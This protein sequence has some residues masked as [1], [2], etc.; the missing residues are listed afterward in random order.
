MA[1][2]PERAAEFY[3]QVFGW[4]ISKWDGPEEYWLLTTGSGEEQ[5]ID[6]GIAR[7]KGEALTVNTISVSSVDEFVAR[8]T[9]HG[10]QVALPKMPVP[11]VGYLAYCKDTEGVLFGIMETDP[12]A[13]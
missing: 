4:Q 11:G 7:S 6:G 3:S 12:S 10:G 13:G 2:N 5:G 1:E 9:Q 8:I